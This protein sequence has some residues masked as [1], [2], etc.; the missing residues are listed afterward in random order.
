MNL[1]SSNETTIL[2][3]S[4][5]LTHDLLVIIGLSTVITL[6]VLLLCEILIKLRRI[7]LTS[8]PSL[9]KNRFY[10]QLVKSNGNL[11]QCLPKFECVRSNCQ[12]SNRCVNY[13]QINERQKSNS[14]SR[15]CR[16]HIGK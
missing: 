14:I 9:P 10:E 12:I 2:N 4:N 8:E 15:V 3:I 5:D 16:I 1:F 7:Y 6:I 13:E 11:C